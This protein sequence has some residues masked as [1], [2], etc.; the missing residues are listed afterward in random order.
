MEK[1]KIDT[2]QLTV[3]GMGWEQPADPSD[4]NNNAKNRRVEVKIYPAEK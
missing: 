4:P 2:N 3:R 1:Y